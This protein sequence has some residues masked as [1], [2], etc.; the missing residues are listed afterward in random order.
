M[1]YGVFDLRV[2]FKVKQY[3]LS[4]Y[5]DNVADRRGITVAYYNGLGPDPNADHDFYI[6]PRTVGLRLDW[7]L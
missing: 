3:D 7:H 1:D 2:G 6:R 4:F 5:A